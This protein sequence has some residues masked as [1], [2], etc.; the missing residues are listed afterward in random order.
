M[1]GAIPVIAVPPF[2]RL[3]P[4]AALLIA[5][6]VLAGGAFPPVRR[7]A[8]RLVVRHRI[9]RGARS[10]KEVRLHRPHRWA[11]PPTIEPLRRA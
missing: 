9:Q 4:V 5:G 7:A 8:N 6:A 11:H 1:A 2:H 3:G 10:A